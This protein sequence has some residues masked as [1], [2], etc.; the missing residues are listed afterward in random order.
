MLLI[1][2]QT[3]PPYTPLNT[4]TTDGEHMYWSPV[5]IEPNPVTTLHTVHY[6][7]PR[8]LPGDN[9]ARSVQA[10]A[11]SVLVYLS[12]DRF[13]ECKAAVKWLQSMRNRR[14]M[15]DGSQ[16]IVGTQPS[17]AGTRA[18][19]AGTRA[20]MAGTRVPRPGTLAPIMGT[21][22]MHVERVHVHL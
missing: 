5:P 14:N 8:P 12:H 13:D 7:Q 17:G 20:P 18:P 1:I 15:F 21:R 10:T 4:P 2:P 16:V 6:M 11:F 22:D 9:D 3:T 19:M